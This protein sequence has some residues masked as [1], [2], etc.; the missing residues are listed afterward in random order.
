MYTPQS[1]LNLSLIIA[2]YERYNELT[3]LLSSLAKQSDSEFEIVIVD[4]GSPKPLKSIVEEFPQLRIQYY[5]KENGGP[6]AARNYGMQRAKGNYFI[7]LDSDTLAPK[8]YIET[9]KKELM[10]QYA[11]F[12]GGADDSTQNFKPLQKAINF[13]MTSFLTTGG[14]RGNKKSI[15][16]FQPRSFNMGICKD[17]F[18]K[19]GGFSNLRYGEDPDLTMTLWELGFT[20]RFFP[21][22]KVFHK[23]RTS[24]LKFAK[25]TFQFGVARPILN[26]RHPKYVQPTFWLP[27]L[28][29]LGFIFAFL[30]SLYSNCFL[31]ITIY[32]IY[33]LLILIFSS[34]QNKSL[35]VG[36]LS[37][38]TTWVQFVSYGWGFLKAQ[39]KL[40]I[41]NKKPEQAFPNHFL[42]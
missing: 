25:Q 11:D 1:H 13:S 26:K 7:F 40:N 28:F 2:V 16:K 27:S 14:I 18:L 29:L 10:Q 35:Y 33:S 42:K 6:G 36:I 21:N 17:A 3:E 5:Y 31:G 19:S 39:F 30:L 8:H 9:V 23:R 24:L 34:V 12:F 20:S 22:L 37:V 32:S 15:A 38:I 41:L 4:D